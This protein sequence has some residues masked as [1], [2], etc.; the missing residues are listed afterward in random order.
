MLYLI[1]SVSVKYKSDQKKSL[2]IMKAIIFFMKSQDRKQCSK[3]LMLSKI[4]RRN[5]RNIINSNQ[6]KTI[7]LFQIPN[8]YI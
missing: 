7:N 1:N 4:D 3:L 5:L 2:H 8:K 6:M